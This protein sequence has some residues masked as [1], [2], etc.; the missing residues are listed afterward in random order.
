MPLNPTQIPNI[1]LTADEWCSKA[2]EFSR[3][4]EL[5]NALECY[6]MAIAEDKECSKAHYNKALVLSGI[7]HTRPQRVESGLNALVTSGAVSLSGPVN[8]GG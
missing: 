1:H 5:E 2:E 7:P 4:G 8:I 3:S 6:N